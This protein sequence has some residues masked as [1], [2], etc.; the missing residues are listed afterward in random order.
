MERNIQKYELSQY[1]KQYIFSTSLINNK[2]RI[3]CQDLSSPNQILYYSDFSLEELIY[4]NKYFS[5]FNSI[6]EVQRQINREVESQRIGVLDNINSFHVIFYIKVS[7]DDEKISIPLKK[8]QQPITSYGSSKQEI[9]TTTTTGAI[10]NKP[11]IYQ[12]VKHTTTPTRH[13]PEK[14]LPTQSFIKTNNAIHTPERRL[15][16]KTVNIQDQNIYVSPNKYERVKYITAPRTNPQYL[17]TS[18]L[19]NKNV[20]FYQKNN[21]SNSYIPTSTIKT[22]RNNNIYLNL[23]NQVTP[24]KNT[25]IKYTSPI[26]SKSNIPN[27]PDPIFTQVG[28]NQQNLSYTFP[29]QTTIQ[30]N[31]ILNSETNN[32]TNNDILQT[33]FTPNKNQTQNYIKNDINKKQILDYIETLPISNDIQYIPSSTTIYSPPR[34]QIQYIPS[35][36]TSTE[37]VIKQ[38]QINK[39]YMEQLFPSTNYNITSTQQCQNCI[40]YSQKIAQL[41]ANL[42][43]VKNDH[44]QLK[45][46]INRLIEE[47]KHLRKTIEILT[48]E[49]KTLKENCGKFKDN[50]TEITILKQENERIVTQYENL[51]ATIQKEFDDYKYLKEKE[52]EQLK[53]QIETLINKNNY[54]TNQYNNSQSE[55]KKIIQSK[56]YTINNGYR[57][58][59]KGDIIHSTNE[60]EFLARKINKDNQKIILNLLYKAT[61]DSDKAESFHEKCDG[62]E[63]TLVLVETVNG[64]R[65]GGYTKCNWRGNSIEKKDDEAF[66]FSLNKMK[67]Y[68]VIPGEFAIGCYPKYGPV[69]LG[70]QIRIYDDA[71][72]NGGTTFEHGLNFNTVEDYELT[73][74]ASKFDIREIEVYSVILE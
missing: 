24:T 62:A 3:S 7:N 64:K 36:D 18:R 38:T 10:V 47:I 43:K 23:N 45:S 25:Q 55:Q 15:P 34:Q 70:C 61:V 8:T 28:T 26:I 22:Q 21:F 74:G 67:I 52:I 42:Q 48:N 14:V 35:N 58:I 39:N 37:A 1:N 30:E 9:I 29:T 20:Q 49:N 59:V 72:T 17:N 66:I 46:E 63:S 16:T 56:Q 31:V 60:L 54:I 50:N 19:Q 11:I 51:K 32:N 71:F 69:F 13:L 4:I 40:L 65:F 53:L 44:D 6:D 68:D 12:S 27:I 5:S 2:I 73:D 33:L 41:E 57:E